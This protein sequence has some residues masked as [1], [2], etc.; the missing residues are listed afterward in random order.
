V[1]LMDS[2]HVLGCV[3]LALL[4]VLATLAEWG[5]APHR[6]L[7]GRL[8]ALLARRGIDVLA[9]VGWLVD[10]L[11]GPWIPRPLSASRA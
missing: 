8:S 3:G 10:R 7:P 5:F 1:F 11:P 4:L 9:A 6:T 2:E